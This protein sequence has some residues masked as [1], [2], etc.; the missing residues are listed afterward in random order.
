MVIEEFLMT[1][2][3]VVYDAVN[4]L[5]VLFV[6]NKRSFASKRRYWKMAFTSSG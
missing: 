4:C 6:A 3:M 1:T 2:I 5:L